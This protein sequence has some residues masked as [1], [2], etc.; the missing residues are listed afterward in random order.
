MYHDLRKVAAWADLTMAD[1]IRLAVD[2]TYA[3]LF[4]LSW[5]DLQPLKEDRRRLIGAAFGRKQ[6]LDRRIAGRRKRA[7]KTVNALQAGA[8]TILPLGGPPSP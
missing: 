5:E 2:Q 1:L 7:M 6:A 3:E 4:L 8:Q